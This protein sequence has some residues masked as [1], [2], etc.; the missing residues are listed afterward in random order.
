MKILVQ[1]CMTHLYLKT[2]SDWTPSASEAKNFPSSESAIV[3]CAEHRIPTVQVVL[4]FDPDKYDI[5]VPITEECEQAASSQN[6]L[7]N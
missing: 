4:K 7:R 6:A 2:L 3:Y 1:N 5:S